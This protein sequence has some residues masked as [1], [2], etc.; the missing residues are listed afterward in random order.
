MNLSIV[1]YR[2]GWKLIFEILLKIV[3]YEI[4][5]SKNTISAIIWATA[6]PRA[7]NLW[8]DF[9]GKKD[10]FVFFEGLM[11][12]FKIAVLHKR[13]SSLFLQHSVLSIHRV[14]IQVYIQRYFLPVFNITIS[15]IRIRFEVSNWFNNIVSLPLHPRQI[16]LDGFTIV[17]KKTKIGEGE[18]SVCFSF[19][20]GMWG[21]SLSL[22]FSV[23][24][25]NASSRGGKSFLERRK[26][27]LIRLS[28]SPRLVHSDSRLLY[29]ARVRTSFVNVSWR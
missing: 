8:D 24:D 13:S 22:F 1:F 15:R 20:Q 9:S 12:Y 27:K 16:H 18:T 11:H 26:S 6:L 23:T 25:I 14:Y 28:I 29:Q 17:K 5:V 19:S 2:T 7:S 10:K 3:S 21:L 4:L